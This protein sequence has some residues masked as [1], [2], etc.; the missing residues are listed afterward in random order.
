MDENATPRYDRHA[1]N[2]DATGISDERARMLLGLP[3]R[4][5][6]RKLSGLAV[7]VGILDFRAFSHLIAH[8]FQPV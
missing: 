1:T 6:L 8:L 7:G 3:P 2:T 5:S 4:H